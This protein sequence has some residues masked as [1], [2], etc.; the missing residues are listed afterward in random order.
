[1]KPDAKPDHDRIEK[2]IQ[3]VIE[4]YVQ[5][6]AKHGSDFISP[7]QLSKVARILIEDEES[8][9]DVATLKTNMNIAVQFGKL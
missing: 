7:K 2:M 6:A 3:V 5:I 9:F 8:N 4:S 1:M